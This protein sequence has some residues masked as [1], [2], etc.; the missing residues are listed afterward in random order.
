[1][2]IMSLISVQVRFMRI[3][4]VIQS[5]KPVKILSKFFVRSYKNHISAIRDSDF[6]A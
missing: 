1:V 4:P 3:G 5:G 2:K 6:F